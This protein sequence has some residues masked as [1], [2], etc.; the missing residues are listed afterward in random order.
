[1]VTRKDLLETTTKVIQ[2]KSS[3]KFEKTFMLSIT[4][5]KYLYKESRITPNILDMSN[6]IE[7]IYLTSKQE[8]CFISIKNKY[9]HD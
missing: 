4:A 1:M 2:N 3:T 6:P 8:K 9:S 7:E 5:D